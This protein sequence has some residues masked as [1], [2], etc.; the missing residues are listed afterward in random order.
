[1]LAIAMRGARDGHPYDERELSA[2]LEASARALLPASSPAPV[3]L[4]QLLIAASRSSHT[5]RK[6]RALVERRMQPGRGVATKK[7]PVRKARGNRVIAGLPFDARQGAQLDDRQVTLANLRAA[8][9]LAVSDSAAARAITQ[10]AQMAAPA[11]TAPTKAPAWLMELREPLATLERLVVVLASFCCGAS[12]GDAWSV[13]MNSAPRRCAYDALLELA[14]DAA[15]AAD[16]AL[17][18]LRAA[19]VEGRTGGAA[20]GAEDHHPSS[21]AVPLA[22]H[23]P[24]L[25]AVRSSLGA[26]LG[27][28][29]HEWRHARVGVP[30]SATAS[31]ATAVAPQST[32]L[33]RLLGLY[34]G[35]LLLEQVLLPSLPA[36]AAT[37]TTLHR[38][39]RL[40]AAAISDDD[41]DSDDENCDDGDDADGTAVGPIAHV[42]NAMWRSDR[43]AAIAATEALACEHVCGLLHLSFSPQIGERTTAETDDDDNDDDD[44]YDADAALRTRVDEVAAFVGAVRS[45]IAGAPPC[46]EVEMKETDETTESLAP[47]VAVSVALACA[48]SERLCARVLAQLLIPP[49][50]VGGGGGGG[51]VGA[52]APDG[53]TALPTTPLTYLKVIECVRAVHAMRTASAATSSTTTPADAARAGTEYECEDEL[54]RDLAD[55]IGTH[56]RAPALGQFGEWAA[57]SNPEIATAAEWGDADDHTAALG[58]AAAATAA[59]RRVTHVAGA[60]LARVSSAAFARMVGLA[61]LAFAPTAVAASIAATGCSAKEAAAVAIAGGSSADEVAPLFYVD[62][63]RTT[64]VFVVRPAPHASLRSSATAPP[65]LRSGGPKEL[66]LLRAPPSS[67]R[68]YGTCHARVV[69]PARCAHTGGRRKPRWRRR[70]VVVIH[71][72]TRGGRR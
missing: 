23:R 48:L 63:V 22:C 14:A 4:R 3:R 59:A 40:A 27:L 49:S 9:A 70:L 62:S 21:T 60:Q 41:D 36:P 61:E 32:A 6:L 67:F 35:V 45:A 16:A 58:D 42:S 33:W 66:L 19:V 7:S 17:R 44:K 38:V 50:S 11:A 37:A 47:R 31:S 72:D 55:V 52:A 25:A 69:V 12:G 2:A 39:N 68:S 34:A 28:W 51:E 13:M 53:I 8:Q 20:P 64:S 54:T 15:D 5:L 26:F 46:D 65:P 1:M 18:A 56:A 24:L 57:R 29:S 71:A 30:S 10:A 43:A